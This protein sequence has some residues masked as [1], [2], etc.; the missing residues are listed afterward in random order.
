MASTVI[1]RP[2]PAL[3]SLVALLL[4]TG[5]V[6]WRVLNRD[7]TTTSAQ[8]C[9][10]A[11]PSS[12]Q[13]VQTALPTP[14]SITVQVLNSTTRNGIAAAARTT[15]IADGF[16][17]PARAV[18]DTTPSRKTNTGVAQLRFGPSGKQAATHLR[19]YF[20]GATLIATTSPTSTVVVALG[21]TY[22]AI[23]TPAAAT[24][25][26]KAARVSVAFPASTPTPAATSR[27]C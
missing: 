15:L 13:P 11:S 24:A 25:A 2:L 3:I 7:D 1:R 9:H 20:P 23:A 14:A 5:I 27:S 22:K 17:V 12:S 6:W 16:K 21:T 19:F 18:D 10:S 8:P 4:L 26:M